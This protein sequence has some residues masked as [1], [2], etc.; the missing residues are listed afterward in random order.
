MLSMRR[1]VIVALTIGTLIGGTAGAT[2]LSATERSAPTRAAH[3]APN[4]GESSAT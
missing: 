1:G 2:V 3:A 4:Y